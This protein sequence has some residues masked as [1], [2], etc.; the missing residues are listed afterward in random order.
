V[1]D[2][3]TDLYGS[4]A[5]VAPGAMIV[6]KPNVT[7]NA[8][9]HTGGTTHVELVEALVVAARA[10]QPARIVVAEGTAAYGISHDSAFPDGGWREM[11]AR[12]GI[13]LYNLEAGE[14]VQ[15]TLDRPRYPHPLP[16]SRLVLE[17]DLFVT[18]PL[19]KTHVSADYTAALKNSFALVPQATR[20]EVHR[21]YLLEEALVDINRMRAPDLIVVDGWDGAEGIAGG[22]DFKRPAGARVMLAGNDAV[23]VDVISR[24]LMGLHMRTRYL[25]WAIDERVGCGD[26]GAITLLGERPAG[27]CHPFM[28]PGQEMCQMVP[29]LTLSDGDAC[30]G[31]RL[32][33]LGALRRARPPRLTS[34]LTVIYG[35]SDGTAPAEGRVLVIGKCAAAA[36]G[37]GSYVPGCPPD[38]EAVRCALVELGVLCQRCQAAAREALDG[39]PAEALEDLRVTAAGDTVFSG[40]KVDPTPRYRALIVGDCSEA[41]HSIVRDR[42]PLLG[43]DPETDVIYVPGCPVE[44]EAIRRALVGV[45]D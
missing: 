24:D 13:E 31:C 7:A 30:S 10:W 45:R 6:I 16:I 26:R 44:V 2:L 39:L 11:A 38:S 3:L 40:P 20:T 14:H 25:Q 33:A 27:L 42:A 37:C 5:P 9:S 18:V 36:A 19:L 17:A 22:T 35:H 23:A 21:R 8:P 28:T 15:V 43:M 4:S 32:A 34:P 1:R 29:G 12:Q 41:Y